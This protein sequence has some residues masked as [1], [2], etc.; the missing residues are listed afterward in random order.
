M[1]LK[2]YNIPD[3]VRGTK[4]YVKILQ[5]SKAINKR[6]YATEQDYHLVKW[7]VESTQRKLFVS[8]TA[9]YKIKGPV[10]EEEAK[11]ETIKPKTKGGLT[12]HEFQ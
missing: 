7:F 11:E 2:D 12:E 1:L 6:Q 4:F 10:V 3:S 8:E 9:D 5:V